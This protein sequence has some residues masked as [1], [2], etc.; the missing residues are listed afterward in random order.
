MVSLATDALVSRLM[1]F[2]IIGEIRDA[3]TIASGTG[4]RD[5]RRL[6]KAHGSG[7]WRKLKG[8]ALVQLRDGTIREAELHWYEATGIG[9][10]ET[11]IKRYL[12]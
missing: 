12:S 8:F 11:K 7:R 6:A 3:Q 4:L 2:K 1:G 5:R 10:K 9:R